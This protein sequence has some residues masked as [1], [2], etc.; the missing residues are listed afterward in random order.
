MHS[1]TG[2]CRSSS[3]NGAH[4]EE[5]SHSVSYAIEVELLKEE[6]GIMVKTPMYGTYSYVRTRTY[7]LVCTRV[8]IY[9]LDSVHKFISE[10]TPMS[11][12]YLQSICLSAY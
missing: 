3:R 7:I 9:K 2:T 11:V 10:I 12:R 1:R 5:K 6:I 8:Q 4:T